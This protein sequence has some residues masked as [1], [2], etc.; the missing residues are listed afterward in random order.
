MSLKYILCLA[1]CFGLTGLSSEWNVLHCAPRR[2]YSQF[3]GVL[4]MFILRIATCH[5]YYEVCLLG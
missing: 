2:H 1:T 3:W 4:R 5:G